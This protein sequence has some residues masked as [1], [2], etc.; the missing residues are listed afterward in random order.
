M[1]RPVVVAATAAT[2]LPGRSGSEFEVATE[3]AEFARHTLAAM[4][5][6]RG[7]DLGRAAR[8]CVTAS[9]GWTAS[10][11]RFES[12]LDATGDTTAIVGAARPPGYPC[13]STAT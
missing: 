4:E 10:L 3:P 11:A 2:G 8:A 7:G 9:C 1:A 13:T 6:A 5:R 12:L